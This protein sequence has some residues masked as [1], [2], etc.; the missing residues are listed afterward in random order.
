MSQCPDKA[1]FEDLEQSYSYAQVREYGKRIGS[2]LAA[3][4]PQNA[5]VPVL[6]D[7]EKFPGKIPLAAA[8][9]AA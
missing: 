4:L 8:Q 6:M 2:A 9:A 7:V 1:A 5:P 3:V